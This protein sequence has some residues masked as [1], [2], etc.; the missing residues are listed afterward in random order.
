MRVY[1][2]DVDPPIPDA[3][4]DSVIWQG[5]TFFF[6]S[7]GSWD[8]TGIVNFTWNFTYNNNDV[9]LYGKSPIFTFNIPGI[10]KNT[11]NATDVWENWATDEMILDVKDSTWP[12]ANAGED[13]TI[14][15]HMVVTFNGNDSFDDVG[16]VNYTWS[17]TYRGKEIYLYGETNTYIFD[18]AGSYIVVLNVSDA[19]GNWARDS[20]NVTVIDITP[21]TANGG[22]NITI[23]QGQ[24]VSFD[25]NQSTDNVGIVNYSWSF[26]YNDTNQT[27]FGVDPKFKFDMQG[28]YIVE[29]RVQDAV[30]LHDK[31]TV[32]IIVY[33]K[34]LPDDGN[35]SMKPHTNAGNNVTIN[36][37]S[38]FSFNSTGSWDNT[39]IVNYTWSLNYG[40]ESITLYG[41]HPSFRFEKEGYY[42]VILIV[43]DEAGN[44]G[45]DVITVI[46]VEENGNDHPENDDNAGVGEEPEEKRSWGTARMMVLIIICSILI[47]A[48][49]YYFLRKEPGKD[50][51][52]KM[53]DEFGRTDAEGE[54]E[55][56]DNEDDL[57][58]EDE[59]EEDHPV[60]Q[61]NDDD[62][63]S[64]ED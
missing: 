41:P 28:L 39:G 19:E 13:I 26:F 49:L 23:I 3:G 50:E 51:V 32:S 42:T 64:E 53:T 33:P 62:T 12:A 58:E 7:S 31:D 29:L 1:V 4:P 8:N 30:N 47:I 59:N 18:D 38:T 55:I 20:L 52:N 34:D 54:P 25:A 6:N 48:V 63:E 45:E 56:S 14:D 57:D 24:T 11:L 10:Y 60:L 21:P 16:L 27:L 9:F 44:I 40:G 15:Q 22:K 35:D 46:V 5:E 36:T 43:R 2:L 17:F 37:N 61:E